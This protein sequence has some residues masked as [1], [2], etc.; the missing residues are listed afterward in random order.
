MR[1]LFLVVIV[2]TAG[3]PGAAGAA[4][5]LNFDDL[6]GTTAYSN[7]QPV[8]LADQLSYKYQPTDGIRFASI[9][10]YVA[11]GDYGA[12]AP[13][14]PNAIAGT[15]AAGT[16]DYA[17]PVYFTFWDP[18]D[19]SLLATTDFFSMRGDLDATGGGVSVTVSAYGLDGT[20][21]GSDT[22]IDNG[23]ETWTLSFPG[24]Y[25]VRFPGTSADPS[26]GGIALDDVT[27]DAVTVPEPQGWV[28]G[29]AAFTAL[30]CTFRRGIKAEPGRLSFVTQLRA[31]L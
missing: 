11:V 7:G 9:S 5:V 17:A 25:T 26:Y 10:N 23:G 8:P 30:F 22:E 20:L 19:T 3:L 29:C 28:V 16:F 27:F 15:S 18:S 31:N 1:L 12:S 24:I 21:L 2:A 13:S 4:I 14:Q 6:P